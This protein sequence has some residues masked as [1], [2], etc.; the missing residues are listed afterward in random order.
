[1][2][3]QKQ[4]INEMRAYAREK[5]ESSEKRQRDE[6]ESLENFYKD[7]FACLRESVAQEKYDI[8]VRRKAQGQVC[9]VV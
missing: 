7:K 9:I 2:E 1:M 8:E 6:I 5:K 4:R 3:I